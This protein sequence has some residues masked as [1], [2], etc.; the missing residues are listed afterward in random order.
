MRTL[1][2]AFSGATTAPA[3]ADARYRM[4]LTRNGVTDTESYMANN[5][6]GDATIP[7]VTPLPPRRDPR[8]PRGA[9]VLYGGTGYCIGR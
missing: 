7:Y 4:C 2:I 8:C 3:T 9:G 1:L 5:H 6:V